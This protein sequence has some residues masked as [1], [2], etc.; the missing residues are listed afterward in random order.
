MDADAL[1][2]RPA[3][4]DDRPDI[5]EL[6]V[7][8]LRWRGDE[9]DRAFFAWKHDENPFGPSPAWVATEA[10]QVVGFRTLLRWEFARGGERLRVVRAVDTASDPDHQGRGIFRRLTLTAVAELTAAGY[11]AV[12]NTPNTQSR[13]GYL[14]MG[15]KEL[16]RPALGTR[17]RGP[18][19]ALRMA[20]SKAA[21]EK[22][23]DDTS[24][25]QPA[26]EA[27]RGSQLD[28]LL[29]ALPPPSGW[30]T[31]RTA[32]YL[33]WRY[34]FEPLHYRALEVRGGLAIFRVRRRGPSREVALC[35]WLAPGPDRRAL[36]RLVGAAGDYLVAADLGA[37][38]G[39]VPIP[40]LGPMVTWRPL[41]RREVPAL[42]DMSF[43]LGD[44]ELF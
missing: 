44:L 34:G 14:K 24:V 3:A 33:R 31:P 23:S 12:F 6:A 22:W 20:R 21:A 39:L 41:A 8:A 15:W 26:D 11:D 7:R 17:P 10:G 27:L 2:I 18:G 40:R 30:A 38:H 32:D 43:R 19:A 1:S 35:E 37:V 36:R 28:S 16:G 5:I 4:P 13:P 42:G 9:R 25:G 29:A